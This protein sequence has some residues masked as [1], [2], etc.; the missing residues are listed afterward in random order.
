MITVLKFKIIYL[1]F[2]LRNES[3]DWVLLIDPNPVVAKLSYFI[4]MYGILQVY[5]HNYFP[6]HLIN[7]FLPLTNANCISFWK[8]SIS[9]Q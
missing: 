6:K 2:F 9:K 4:A 8:I 7:L 1:Q 3:C 5:F